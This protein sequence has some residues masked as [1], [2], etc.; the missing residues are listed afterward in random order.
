MEYWS[1]G[2]LNNGLNEYQNGRIMVGSLI[3]PASSQKIK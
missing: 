1:G 2:V 3:K